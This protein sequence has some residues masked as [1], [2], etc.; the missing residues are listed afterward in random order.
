[1]KATY[2]ESAQKWGA[3]YKARERSNQMGCAMQLAA[4]VFEA[5]S[6]GKEAQDEVP[7]SQREILAGAIAEIQEAAREE[8]RAEYRAEARAMV[9]GAVRIAHRELDRLASDVALGKRFDADQRPKCQRHKSGACSTCGRAMSQGEHN[10]RECE[11]AP[12]QACV[13]AL[14]GGGQ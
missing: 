10:I 9:A 6:R 3:S 8:L 13:C 11:G 4:H 1:M 12:L 7:F 2:R 14:P 5:V